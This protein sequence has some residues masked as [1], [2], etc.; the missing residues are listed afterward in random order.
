MASDKE[1]PMQKKVEHNKMFV[2]YMGRLACRVFILLCAI[3]G[4]FVHKDMIV[5]IMTDDFFHGFTPLHALWIV[6]MAGMII[7]LLP[8][9]ITMSGFKSRPINYREPEGGYD[10]I[11]LFEYVQKMNARA[12][13]VLLIWLSFN[14]IFAA[15]YL[16]GIIGVAELLLLTLFY[17]TADMLCMMLFCPFQKYIMG[18][19]CCVNCRIFDWGHMMMY[20]PMI[21]ICS[22]FSW[23][24]IFTAL[25]VM[26]RWELIFT[27]HP[28]RFWRGSNTSIRCEN[29]K[30][31]LCRIKKPIVSGVDKVA[32]VMPA[33]ASMIGATAEEL[34]K[35]FEETSKK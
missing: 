18:N 13:Q 11:Q 5:H 32:S 22:F 33:P 19:R 29:C 35:E 31:K 23:S 17:W 16:G 3:Y 27:K 20:T 34:D 9:R 14:A 26:I 30:D 4:Y 2:I 28:E 7:H 10:Q 21:L 12:W 8:V 1:F 6:L 24:L 15:L 25:I